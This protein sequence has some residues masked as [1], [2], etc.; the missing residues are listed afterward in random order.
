MKAFPHVVLSLALGWFT[1]IAAPAALIYLGQPALGESVWGAMFSWYLEVAGWVETAAWK[2]LPWPRLFPEGGA[3][4]AFALVLVCIFVSW[5]L[6]FATLW[7][8]G[9]RAWTRHN[10]T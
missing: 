1:A 5:G 10:D 7:Y 6:L 4:G 9:I 8:F 3:P 2:A